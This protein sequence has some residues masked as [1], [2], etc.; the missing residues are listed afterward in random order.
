MDAPTNLKHKPL[1][2]ISNYDAF[3]GIYA[4]N[5]DA[6]ALSIG[7]AQY[8]KDKETLSAKVWRK[9]KDKWSRMSE[10]L[11]IHRVFDL[12]ILFLLALSEEEDKGCNLGKYHVH[13]DGE[14]I[15]R[16]LSSNKE[17]SDVL[18][19]RINMLKKILVHF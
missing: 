11:P 16:Q 6:K 17:Y 12:T 4:G 10:E 15:L 13:S 7:F 18:K 3:D 19:S 1:V 5:T 14:Q 8:S 2:S 9:P